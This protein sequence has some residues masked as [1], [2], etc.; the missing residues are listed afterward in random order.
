MTGSLCSPAAVSPT[1]L[2]FPPGHVWSVVSL[3][4]VTDWEW[5]PRVSRV[6]SGE[7]RLRHQS[8]G[9]AG[10]S[11]Q[12]TSATYDQ[13]SCEAYCAGTIT[14]DS[15]CYPQQAAFD[16]CLLDDSDAAYECDDEGNASVIDGTCDDEL[17]AYVTC[18][19]G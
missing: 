14:P 13:A 3:G 2:P 8:A 10:P 5:V 1:I 11:T 6:D 12:R 16:P 18:L 15:P 9:R 4:T 7:G 19:T 17:N